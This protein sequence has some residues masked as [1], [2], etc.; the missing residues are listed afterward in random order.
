MQLRLQRYEAPSLTG[1]SLFTKCHLKVTRQ[2]ARR[3]QQPAAAAR[4][5]FRVRFNLRLNL[6]RMG[7]HPEKW[8]PP[9]TCV[10]LSPIWPAVQLGLLCTSPI[11]K[12]YKYKE[13]DVEAWIT[14]TYFHHQRW[15]TMY[16]LPVSNNT[17]LPSGRHH[18]TILKIWSHGSGSLSHKGKMQVFRFIEL[19]R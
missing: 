13:K 8:A 1:S 12:C 17:T 9:H 10:C 19:R 2:V 15:V 18:H 7:Q 6:Q 3:E 5:S 4:R 14:C 16:V 11:N